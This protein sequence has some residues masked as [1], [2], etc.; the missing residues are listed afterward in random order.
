LCTGDSAL[1]FGDYYIEL[2]DADEPTGIMY[3][4]LVNVSVLE[5]VGAQQ[6]S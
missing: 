2:A 1:A 4:S 3:T 5:E 6:R